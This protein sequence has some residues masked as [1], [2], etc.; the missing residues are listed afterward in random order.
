MVAFLLERGRLESVAADVED[1]CAA[2]VERSSKRLATAREPVQSGR[3]ALY[4]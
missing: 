4:G 1:A 3:P 2:L